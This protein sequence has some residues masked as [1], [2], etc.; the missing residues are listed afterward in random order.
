MPSAWSFGV[1]GNRSSLEAVTFAGS[2]I[3]QRR[4]P[5]VNSENAVHFFYPIPHV[6][7]EKPPARFWAARIYHAT[8]GA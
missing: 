4:R 3:Y 5:L 2:S 1:I 8:K 6:L 7:S